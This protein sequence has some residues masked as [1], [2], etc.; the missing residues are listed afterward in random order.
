MVPFRVLCLI[1]SAKPENIPNNK[2]IK[3][4]N[5]YT[6][7]QVDRLHL[8]GGSI[9]YKLYELNIDDCFPYTYFGA[10]R[11]AVIADDLCDEEELEKILNDLFE[12]ASKEEIEIKQNAMLN[13]RKTQCIPRTIY[14]KKW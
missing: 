2:W 6:V 1:D 14:Q 7:V 4:N 10:W 11:F 9:G 3:K 12:E 5:I 8:S 13:G